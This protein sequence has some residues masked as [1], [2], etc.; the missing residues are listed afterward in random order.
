MAGEYS[1][2]NRQGKISL[3]GNTAGKEKAKT[4]LAD[5]LKLGDSYWDYEKQELNTWSEEAGDWV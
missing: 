3:E 5:K 1:N 2:A 4:D